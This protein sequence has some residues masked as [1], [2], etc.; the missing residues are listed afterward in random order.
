MVTTLSSAIRPQLSTKFGEKG[1]VPRS[2][3]SLTPGAQNLRKISLS[4]DVMI[5]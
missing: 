4:S 1:F 3:P 2:S 5:L